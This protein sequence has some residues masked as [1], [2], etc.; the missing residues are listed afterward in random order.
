MLTS[1]TYLSQLIHDYHA[2]YVLIILCTEDDASFVAK[3]FS[4]SAPSIWNYSYT[5]LAVDPLNF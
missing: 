5:S 4:V 3:T 1:T 2:H